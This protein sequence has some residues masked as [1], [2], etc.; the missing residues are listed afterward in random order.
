LFS[1]LLSCEDYNLQIRARV[2][3]GSE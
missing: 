3:E 2:Q 1:G